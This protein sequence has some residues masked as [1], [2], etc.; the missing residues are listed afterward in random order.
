MIEDLKSSM[1]SGGYPLPLGKGWPASQK[2]VLRGAG[3]TPAAKRRQRANRLRDRAPRCVPARADALTGAEG[4]I[5]GTQLAWC[6][7]PRRGLRAEHVSMWIPQEPGRPR[8]LLGIEPSAGT[9]L[10]HPAGKACPPPLHCNW[11]P[12]RYR[13]AKETKQGGTDNEESE[14]AVVPTKAGNRSAGTR[15][16]KGLAMTWTRCEDR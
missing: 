13:R 1:E 9:A 4:S 10:K 3:A 14:R 5:V 6:R 15:W 8:C 2:R 11:A 16:R 12:P 7:R